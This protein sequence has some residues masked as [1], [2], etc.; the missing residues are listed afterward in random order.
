MSGRPS[1]YVT[2][3]PNMGYDPIPV[4][5]DNGN[6]DDINTTT[7]YSQASNLVSTFDENDSEYTD[8]G[9]I[10]DFDL[11]NVALP[12][13]LNEINPDLMGD[14]GREVPEVLNA[15]LEQDNVFF[16]SLGSLNSSWRE[17]S[18][19]QQGQGQGQGPGQGQGQGQQAQGQGQGKGGKK[20]PGAASSTTYAT[21]TTTM[22]GASSGYN[23]MGGGAGMGYGN[24]AAGGMGAQMNPYAP[25]Q[26][27]AAMG[28]YQGMGYGAPAMAMPAG[29]MSAAAA[30]SKKRPKP[31]GGAPK[32]AANQA[33]FETG[34]QG[35]VSSEYS[36][37]APAATPM[38]QPPRGGARPLQSAAVVRSSAAVA[39]PSM[40][41]GGHSHGH[42]HA[43]DGD[44]SGDEDTG[45][46][47]AKKG[48]RA[49][50]NRQSAAASRERKKQHIQEL[51]RRV[52]MLS[53][54]NA[55]LQVEQLKAL[56]T[57]IQSE[58]S[59]LEENKKLKKKLVMQDMKI[60]KLAKKLN[61]AGIAEEES[62]KRPSTWAG[63]D[64]GAKK[65]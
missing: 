8:L 63:S 22:T 36:Q 34:P 4:N 5:N 62:L 26:Q 14:M 56:R 11:E 65:N 9:A 28:Q 32:R 46:P 64:W 61:D 60:E 15:L 50:R 23:A 1:H 52:S 58:K 48:I 30:G 16:N 6:N 19:G 51:E 53:A 35:E 43:E 29:G 55:Q 18:G 20:S 41:A 21:A 49:E 40:G 37:G 7:E 12:E 25:M 47:G 38:Q 57:R 31:A 42:A 59:L 33:G 10:M 54:E 3:Q 17:D 13:L 27:Q 44:S 39:N 45:E 2:Q 24:V